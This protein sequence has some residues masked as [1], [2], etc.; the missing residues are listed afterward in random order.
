ML[1]N[2][3][4]SIWFQLFGHKT[5]KNKLGKDYM[6]AANG[7]NLSRMNPAWYHDLNNCAIKKS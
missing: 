3:W 1:L 6:N 7:R 2:T 5:G 4:K